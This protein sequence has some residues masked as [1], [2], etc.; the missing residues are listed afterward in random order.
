MVMWW[1]GGVRC[2][3][4]HTTPNWYDSS[5]TEC[6]HTGLSSCYTCVMP[7]T[8]VPLQP[9]IHRHTSTLIMHQVTTCHHPNVP[10]HPDVH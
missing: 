9:H 1:C 7:R 5:N 2:G 10:D 3:G 4:V 6:N 8:G